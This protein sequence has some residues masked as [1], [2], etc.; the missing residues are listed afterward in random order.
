M[1]HALFYILGA[2]WRRIDGTNW[3]PMIFR[4]ITMPL[5]AVGALFVSG[6]SG[7][8]W[9]AYLLITVITFISLF[10]GFDDWTD[11][12]EMSLRYTK[13]AVL[14]C[15][16]A[17]T[18]GGALTVDALTYIGL[19]LAAGL[20]YPVF[21]RLPERWFPKVRIGET[22]IIDGYTSYCELIVGSCVLGGLTVF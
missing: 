18:L 3:T 11:F 17:V 2:I 7:M 9:Y 22:L 21:S 12:K 15:L 6:I 14:A 8:P 20:T 16:V 19:N 13:Y 5:I 1:V 4:Q 10:D